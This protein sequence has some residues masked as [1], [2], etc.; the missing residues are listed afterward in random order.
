LDEEFPVV[1]ELDAGLVAEAELDEEPP[2]VPELDE[3]PPDVPDLDDEC[4]TR[5]EAMSRTAMTVA[6]APTA[7]RPPAARNH[8]LAI[9]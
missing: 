6:S 5:P 2:D 8:T 7:T 9:Q 4:A 1:P 3:E